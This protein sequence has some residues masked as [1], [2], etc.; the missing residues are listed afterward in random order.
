[1]AAL[2]VSM[3]VLLASC[4]RSPS[5]AE[6]AKP[7]NP[8]DVRNEQLWIVESIVRDIADMAIYASSGKDA[9]LPGDALTIKPQPADA[10]GYH[11]NVVI[12]LPGE[13]KSLELPVDIE[14]PIWDRA[15][16]QPLAHALLEQ[17]KLA[18]KVDS[19]ATN[20]N[21]LRL[22]ASPT[23]EGI[24]QQNIRVSALLNEHPLSPE[25]HEQAALIVGVLGLR[26]N[27]G[28]FWDTRGMCNRATAHLALATALRGNQPMSDS[29]EVGE[30]LIG[31]L[32]DTKKDCEQRIE[33]LKSRAL[34]NPELSP[35]IIAAQLR[36][37]RD[38][39]ILEH[40]STASLLERIE[41]FRAQCEAISPDIASQQ[42]LKKSPENI[43]DW[44]RILLQF[45]FSVGDGHTFTKRGLKSEFLEISQ[46]FPGI[47]A[48]KLT[49]ET[50]AETLN[51][52]PGE[53]V[54]RD[55]SGNAR[56]TVIDDG[57]WALFFQRH[58]CHVA[59]R[60]DCFLRK[61]WGV[62][63]QAA[64]F[65]AAIG[66]LFSKLTL[67]PM[68]FVTWDNPHHEDQETIAKAAELARQHPEWVP[69]VI[70]G[71]IPHNASIKPLAIGRWFSPAL[72]AG[73]AYC[74]N[75]RNRSVP[76]LK[77]P[78]IA[79]LQKL[80][81]IAPW[82]FGVALDYM[83]ALYNKNP[84]PEQC[85]SVIG[86]FLDF[87]V[88]AMRWYA[89]YVKD[90]PKEYVSI[91][92]KIAN[93]DPEEYLTLGRYYREHKMDDAAAEAIEAAIKNNVDP[94]SV[95][96]STGWLVD[97]YFDR[98]KKDRALE[99]A[100][101]AAEVYSN[102][103]L[104]TMAKLQERMDNS[105]EAE[106]FFEKIKERYDDAGPLIAFYQRQVTLHPNADFAEKL[107]LNI[108]AIFPGGI[109]TVTLA[110]FAEP[111]KKGVIISKDNNLLL[112]CG[113]KAGTI[114]VA[115]DGKQTENF[116]QY[117]TVRDL[118]DSPHMEF[119]VFQNGKYNLVKA[120]VPERRFHIDFFSWPR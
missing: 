105:H 61:K 83:Q 27:A 57:M 91:C 109:K 6:P 17:L 25:A 90:D 71:T 114:I 101:D 69:A 28:S 73:T 70:W 13:S 20:E 103:G 93:V 106:S 95:T 54:A 113:L 23:A 15:A 1:M 18:G 10:R 30:L 24:Q 37:R 116:P 97:Y 104:T 112:K 115:L 34:A 3:L 44:S 12:H 51:K 62:P 11:Y 31:L 111:P 49:A 76:K 48:G 78:S 82:H 39:R 100:K 75:G 102:V 117:K 33:K 2:C 60:T 36:N 94:V 84:T 42:L 80:Y 96:Y 107:R 81:D 63:D 110:D 56:I 118:T 40:P 74:Y 35:W 59:A 77:T 43:A 52:L 85:R 53:A 50:L 46:I 8:P 32:D 119:I 14:G 26:E 5:T 66:T 92:Q 47:R 45:D 88:G 38:W 22:L 120:E 68:M 99:I 7:E 4:K 98:G 72:P 79:D 29:G 65:E 87:N 21:P 55:A 89:H 108:N 67:A 19:I 9:P 16:Y 86:P 58:L 64:E 41:Y